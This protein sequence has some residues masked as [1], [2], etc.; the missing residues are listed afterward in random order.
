MSALQKKYL[1]IIAGPT[2]VGKTAFSI[3]LAQAL[4][5]EIISADSRQLYQQMNIG[6]AKPDEA[7]RKAVPHHFIDILSP[8]TEYNAGQF[9]RDALALLERL[10]KKYDTVVVAGGSGLYVQALVRGMD[11]MPEVP[12]TVREALNQELQEGGAAASSG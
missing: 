4:N 6:T 10:Y 3:R 2:A 12:A 7:E 8:E 9:E 11:Q 1:I 5:T